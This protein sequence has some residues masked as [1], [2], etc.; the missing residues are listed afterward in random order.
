MLVEERSH[1]HSCPGNETL[2]IKT[3]CGHFERRYRTINK[4]AR[5]SVEKKRMLLVQSL[6]TSNGGSILGPTTGGKG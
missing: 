4:Q 3:C 5:A 6:P 2:T 1:H